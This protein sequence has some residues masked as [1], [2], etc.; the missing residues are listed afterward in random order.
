MLC[1]CQYSCCK[2]RLSSFHELDMHYMQ[3][4]YSL[5]ICRIA[6]WGLVGS[7]WKDHTRF[8]KCHFLSFWLLLAPTGAVAVLM[9][10]RLSG[11]KSPEKEGAYQRVC[12]ASR[13]IKEHC[14]QSRSLKVDTS[15]SCSYTLYT[16]I[17][18]RKKSNLHYVHA[19]IAA[20]M[21]GLSYA[22]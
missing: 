9:S 17:W 22:K 12:S 15:S 18:I 19:C 20:S 10:F 5:A 11:T 4:E 3:Y 14:N 7:P 6:E 8:R 21:S 13:A 2:Y 1:Y 16:R